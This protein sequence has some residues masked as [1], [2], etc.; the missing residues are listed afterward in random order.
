MLLCISTDACLILLYVLVVQPYKKT[1]M[2]VLDGLL[3]ALIGFLILL[4]L[5]FLH[6]L[7]SAR[8]ETLPLIIVITSSVPMLVLPSADNLR[9]S[10]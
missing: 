2:N 6:I 10:T 8:S 3:L 4:L 5:T 7:P 1:Y 9:E